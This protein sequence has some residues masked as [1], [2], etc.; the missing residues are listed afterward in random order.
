M[1]VASSTRAAMSSA[2]PINATMI[3][4]AGPIVGASSVQGVEGGQAWYVA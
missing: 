1:N 2:A 3:N 4:R